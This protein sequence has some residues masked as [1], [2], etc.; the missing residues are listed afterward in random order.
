MG[1]CRGVALARGHGQRDSRVSHA[2]F[3]GHDPTA[4]VAFPSASDL[5]RSRWSVNRTF[6]VPVEDGEER[7]ALGAFTSTE[8]ELVHHDENGDSHTKDPAEGK[9]TADGCND[10]RNAYI[11]T[12]R[13]RR[14]S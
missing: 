10:D 8:E 6:N 13:R 11:P 5:D 7:P 3:S 4:L 9:D 12:V 2:V 14:P 1:G